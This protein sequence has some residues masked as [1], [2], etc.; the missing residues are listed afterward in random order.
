M[1]P[2]A[3]LVTGSSRGIG[4][5]A[6]VALAQEGFSI[7]VNGPVADDELAAAAETI[8]AL[9]V[10]VVT[11]PFDVSDIAVHDSKL[12]EIETEIGPLTTLVNNAGVGVMQRGDLLEVTEESYDRC[13]AVN[14]KAMFFLSQAFAKRLLSR[15]R[16]ANAF[17]SI[18]NVT[19]SNAVAVAAPRAEYCASKAAAAMIS[20]TFAVRLGQ[21]NIAVYDVQPGL[22]S[23]DMTAPVIE[24]YDQRAK[25]GLTLFPR[26]G[27]PED[28]GRIIASLASG[29]LPYTTGQ[30]ISADAGMLVPRF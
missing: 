11:T 20:K 14:T 28:M 13:M 30:A 3:A 5:A 1:T 29:K 26:V 12:A 4:L 24:M 7:A 16:D 19:S 27:Q 21:E 23:T 6:A 17:H 2:Q 18:V 25:D 10:P 15:K 8:R 9:G 22:I